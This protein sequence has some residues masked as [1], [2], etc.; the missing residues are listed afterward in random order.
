MAGEQLSTVLV[1][2][3]GPACNMACSYCFYRSKKERFAAPTRMSPQT[4][5]TMT[6]QLLSQSSEELTFSWQGGEPT[7]MGPDFFRQALQ[8]Q[9][10]YRRPRQKIH[11]A[12]MTNGFALDT[13][14]CQLFRESNMMVGLS[15]D[16][17]RELHDEYRSSQHGQPTWQHAVRAARMLIDHG[18]VTNAVTVATD[19]SVDHGREIYRFLTGMGFDHLQFVPCVETDLQD[20][21]KLAPFSVSP[22][23]YGRLL[24]DLFDCWREDFVDRVPS[25]SVRW[26]DGV[27]H[28]YLGLPPTECTAA[29]SCGKYLVVE[30]DGSVYSCD[31]FVDDD[32]Q[33]GNLHE[34][35]LGAMFHSR[36][37]RD[38]GRAKGDLPPD[39]QRCEWLSHCHG[40]CPKNRRLRSDGR[41]ILCEGYRHFFE[42]ADREMTR[43]ARRWLERMATDPPRQP[44]VG[45]NQPCP[46]GSGKKFKRCCERT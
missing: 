29:D 1:K 8:L 16:G 11:N 37:H 33:L 38:F 26:L 15:I 19:R 25:V 31:F 27:L 12:I 20:P 3:A 40:G 35:S 24:C 28:H 23:G 5:E 46:C 10:R 6:R 34:Q 32:H 4:L 22:K 2:P 14:W 45:R 9:R 21:E 30:H 7:L 13:G 43:L 41:T 42:Y 44:K 18:V 39:C 17:R 36:A